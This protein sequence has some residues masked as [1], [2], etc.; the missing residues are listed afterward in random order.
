[1]FNVQVEI[2]KGTVTLTRVG[3]ILWLAIPWLITS[4]GAVRDS[5]FE[6]RTSGVRIAKQLALRYCLANIFDHVVAVNTTLGMM[7]V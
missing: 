7:S 5:I 4:T 2:V 6:C 1:L 3:A